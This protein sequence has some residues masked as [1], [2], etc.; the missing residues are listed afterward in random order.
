MGGKPKSVT[1]LFQLVDFV[2]GATG[3]SGFT[4]RLGEAAACGLAD[5]TVSSRCCTSGG[6]ST[7]NSRTKLSHFDF[8]SGFS[9]TYFVLLLSR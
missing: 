6:I 4:G 5:A 8:A 9:M 2:F 7:A 1:R 3:V